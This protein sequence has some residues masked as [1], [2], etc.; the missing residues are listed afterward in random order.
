M[1]EQLQEAV[2]TGVDVI[3]AGT[4]IG[5]V[6]N[7]LPLVAVFFTIVWTGLRIYVMIYGPIYKPK[8]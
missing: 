6:A 5:V 3:A 8:D 4:T 1:S 2:K 7:V